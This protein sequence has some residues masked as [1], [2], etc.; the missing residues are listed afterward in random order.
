MTI[1]K[2]LLYL[3]RRI[4]KVRRVFSP[5]TLR[6]VLIEETEEIPKDLSIWELGINI[7]KKSFND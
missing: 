5:P 3:N 6:M 4:D 7:E 1:W 2:Q